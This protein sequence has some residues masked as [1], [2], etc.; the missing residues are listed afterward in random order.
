[1]KYICWLNIQ[2]SVLWRVAK[3]LS[4]KQDPRC[5]KVNTASQCKNKIRCIKFSTNTF[6]K[7]TWETEAADFWTQACS[8]S[9]F[10]H[11]TAICL[12]PHDSSNWDS[13]ITSQLGY[14]HTLC[15]QKH[16]FSLHFRI[17]VNMLK[18]WYINDHL[19]IFL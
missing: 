3:R 1:M 2:K 8:N 4:Y 9:Y 6:N 17:K 12:N 15:P 13:G 18:C 16:C 11:E 19:S 10:A 14:K 5:L 7:P